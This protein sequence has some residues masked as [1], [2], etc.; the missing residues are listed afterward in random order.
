M[1]YKSAHRFGSHVSRTKYGE[2]LLASDGDGFTYGE[3]TIRNAPEMRVVTPEELTLLISASA[4]KD[5]ELGSITYPPKVPAALDLARD[6][7][8]TYLYDTDM[9][10]VEVTDRYV[11]ELITQLEAFEGTDYTPREEEVVRY[12]MTVHE[13]VLQDTPELQTV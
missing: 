8:D 13:A 1:A 9:D 5:I 12:V 6:F 4:Q 7:F 11:V 10:R 2:Q 3:M